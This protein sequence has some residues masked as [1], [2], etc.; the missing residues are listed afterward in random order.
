MTTS[1]PLDQD[2]QQSDKD[3]SKLGYVKELYIELPGYKYL[4]SPLESSDTT[5]EERFIGRHDIQKR[6]LNILKHSKNSGAYLVTGYR[7]MGKTSFVNKVLNE[8][9]SYTNNNCKI[10][11]ICL[12]QDKPD[13]KDIYRQILYGIKTSLYR[14]WFIFLD[15]IHITISAIFFIVFFGSSI[16]ID[17]TS[18][19]KK[20]TILQSNTYSLLLVFSA[21]FSYLAFYL[22]KYTATKVSRE[23]AFYA[24]VL[25]LIDRVNAEITNER[26]VQGSS[27]NIFPI[28]ILSKSVIRFPIAGVKEIEQELIN[29][30]KKYKRKNSKN[31]I[32]VFDEL[33]KVEPVSK[34]PNY[35]DDMD[36]FKEKK[37]AVDTNDLFRE[38][39]KM[40]IDILAGLKNFITIAPVKFIFIAGREMFDASLAD[41][42]D[43]QS[44]LSSIFH[45]IINVESFLKDKSVKNTSGMTNLIE[46]YLKVLLLNGADEKSEEPLFKIYYER[47]TN[48]P[49]MLEKELAQKVIFT[50]QNFLIY[51]TYR[52]SGAPHKINKLIEELIVSD[53][54]D[55]PS[56]KRI[57]IEEK[58][59]LRADE[60]AKPKKTNKD[61]V[62]EKL[63]LKINYFNQYRF[64]YISYLFRPF[65]LSYSPYLKQ[66]S[67]NILVSTPFL[68][69]HL[70]KFHPF[71]FSMQNLEL[72]PEVLHTN[73]QPIIRYFTEELVFFLG[74][75]IIRTTEIGLF[76]YKFFKKVHNEIEFL[77]KTFEDESAA[78]N[79]TLDENYHIKLQLRTR[80]KE[81][82][83]IYKDFISTPENKHI[84]SISY[85]N[86]LVGDLHFFDQEYN[87]AIVAYQ[88]SIHSLRSS[89][90]NFN[91]I[92]SVINL[93]QVNLKIGLSFEKMKSYEQALIYYSL[94]CNVAKD[95][96]SYWDKK[97]SADKK[98]NDE[99]KAYPPSSINEILQF[100]VQG[101]LAKLYVQEK[102]SIEGVTIEKIIY[103]DRIFRQLL[104]ISKTVIKRWNK[105]IMSNFYINM[106]TLIFFKNMNYSPVALE[107]LYKINE[108]NRIELHRSEL[109]DGL[110]LAY[111][112]RKHQSSPASIGFSP[113]AYILYKFSLMS[114]LKVKSSTK[115]TLTELLKNCIDQVLNKE[116]HSVDD[117]FM[118]NKINFTKT[119]LKNIAV[120]LTK[121]G[122]VILSFL[123]HS[124]SSE[125]AY[126]INDVFG[127]ITNYEKAGQDKYSHF[128]HFSENKNI[129]DVSF[130]LKIYYLASEVYLKAGVNVSASFQ[131][132]KILHVIRATVSIKSST[133]QVSQKQQITSF[134]QLLE[135]LIV[136]KILELTSLNSSSSDRPQ[137]DKFKYYFGKQGFFHPKSL[138]KNIYTN[139]SN[140]PEIKEALLFYAAI[141]IKSW[142]FIDID[143]LADS[144]FNKN[145]PVFEEQ[146]L[147]FS[148]PSI[149]SQFTR[150]LEL[151]FQEMSNAVI[152]KNIIL[153][154]LKCVE[155]GILEVWEEKFKELKSLD[156]VDHESFLTNFFEE[157]KDMKNHT[158]WLERFSMLC[159]NSVFCLHRIIK[160]INIC[161]ITYMMSY[162]YLANFHRR[163]GYWLKRLELCRLLYK[164]QL[165]SFDVDTNLVD[166]IGAD[167]LRTLDS[168]SQFQLA[169]QNYHRA[170][171]LHTQGKTYQRQISNMV[172]LE[173]DYNDNLYHYCAA[174]ERQQINSGRILLYIEIL[175][176]EMKNSQLLRIDR[177]WNLDDSET[178]S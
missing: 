123:P 13:I 17:C 66:Y 42:N 160:I 163:L 7:G 51:L 43:R 9:K 19:L 15:N 146:S 54:N 46:E 140:G 61:N 87:E 67:D 37:G 133:D 91:N 125:D 16:L 11:N 28:N 121:I 23:Y 33:D 2:P 98:T 20:S 150:V 118:S 149:S 178:S 88:D 32:F 171:Q 103:T 30:L 148:E 139:I 29:L 153:A 169:L 63:Y 39:K 82:R 8:Y 173:D 144:I 129:I 62:K 55:V 162:S 53:I 81:L 122:D 156:E 10:I 159:V 132:R 14:G 174:V 57:L 134:F 136:N 59:I 135:K 90:P 92:E 27:G 79:F 147:L 76:E 5:E 100:A 12:N 120:T 1:S 85:L 142:E 58:N 110:S 97:I 74:Q 71:A 56:W 131:L 38:R 161:G 165:I 104:N 124:S 168:T 175:E 44:S 89:S 170:I 48:S 18:I 4:H 164:R 45:H 138:T 102:L 24:N 78:F 6:F 47:L 86:I 75:N 108:L 172:Y 128:L 166:L 73:R 117:I 143:D 50:L 106:G 94:V 31:L 25:S 26:G 96:F 152:L 167:A 83:S 105:D 70:I 35:H 49:G 3:Y 109:S 36:T 113:Y 80:I 64:A 151:N 68:M 127:N 145:K 111:K 112:N 72:L 158:L 154:K 99:T 60:I 77:S 41:I 69:H 95:F 34:N 126:P 155:V 101:F 176:K 93:I 40:I 114:L 177:Y 84:Y 141:K 22:L 52:S 137:I 107:G 116:L 130:L 65:I 115:I 157:Y 119:E 21:V